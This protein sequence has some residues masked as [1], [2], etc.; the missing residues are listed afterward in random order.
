MSIYCHPTSEARFPFIICRNY[1][2]IVPHRA[3]NDWGKKQSDST[4][5]T[6]YRR[7]SRRATQRPFSLV[8]CG[9]RNLATKALG[10]TTSMLPSGAPEKGKQKVIKGKPAEDVGWP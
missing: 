3:H 4:G 8:I 1:P 2:L 5:L 10:A 9:W 7:V 6:L